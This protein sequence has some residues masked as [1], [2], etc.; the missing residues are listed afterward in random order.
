M[1]ALLLS[2]ALTAAA[3]AAPSPTLD[4]TPVSDEAYLEMAHRLGD[5]A[6]LDAAMTTLVGTTM[7]VAMI[8]AGSC[9]ASACGKPNSADPY[10]YFTIKV[11]WCTNGT[12]H[13]ACVPLRSSVIWTSCFSD[14]IDAKN[15][16][17]APPPICMQGPNEER[18]Y[19]MRWRGGNACPGGPAQSSDVWVRGMG[20][21]TWEYGDG[22]ESSCISCVQD[23]CGDY[24]EV[25]TAA[26]TPATCPDL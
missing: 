24:D 6:V 20:M 2:A 7:P 19:K 23:D 5:P 25:C 11:A 8:S 12:W 26:E 1:L 18:W 10:D 14:W 13:C 21:I 16:C 3:A 22:L 9:S 17:P 15:N 4:R